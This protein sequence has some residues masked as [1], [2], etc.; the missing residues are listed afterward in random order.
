MAE[1]FAYWN[2]LLSMHKLEQ[3]TGPEMSCGWPLLLAASFPAKSKLSNTSVPARSCFS[4]W[5]TS[6]KARDFFQDIGDLGVVS[7]EKRWPAV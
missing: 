5:A 4:S 1:F 2:A 7:Y 3:P 6:C